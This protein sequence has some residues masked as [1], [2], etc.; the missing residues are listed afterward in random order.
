MTLEKIEQKVRTIIADQMGLGEDEVRN[1]SRIID[2]LGADSLDA[3]EIA[4]AIE[5]DFEIE[6]EDEDI[7]SMRTVD[8]VVKYIVRVQR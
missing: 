1:S 4:M 5:E 2:D 8:D 7:E 6:V 3:V